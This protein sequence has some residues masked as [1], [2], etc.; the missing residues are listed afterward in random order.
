M[1]VRIA[2]SAGFCMGVRK[3]M[4]AVLEASQ[5]NLKTYTLGPLIHNPQAI[6]ML[7]SRNIY[8]ADRIDDSLAG[9]TVV[10]R[11]HG[12]TLEKRQKLS[13][14]GANIVDGTC[15][16]VLWS[17][18]IIKKYHALD[19]TIV[20][21]GDRGH[22]EIEALL[23]YAGDAGTVVETL[24]EARE[25]PGMDDVCV[26]AQTTFNNESYCTISEEICRHAVGDCH[27]AYTVCKSTERR[28]ED[29]RKLAEVTDAT[30]VVGGR[31][32]ANTR[33]LAEISRSLG[34]PTFL[35]EDSSD[36]DLKEL[37]RFSEIGVTAGASTPNWVIKQII[38]TITGYTPE[39][40]RSLQ[41]LLMTLAFFAIEGNIVLCA[42]ASALTFAL[43]SLMDLPLTWFVILMPFFYLF[44]LHAFNKYLE[45]NWKQIAGAEQ[46]QRL[47]RFW[48]IYLTTALASFIVT[49][50]IT[51]I[52]GLFTFVL[53][54][55]SYLLGFLYSIRIIPAGWNI[56][57]K[58]LR[59]I[60][61]SKDF[62][63]AAAWM[64]AVVGLPVITF[65]TVPEAT[66]IVAAAFV[67]VLV[68]TRTSL[69][70]LSGIQSD[71]LVGHETIPV[72]LGKKKTIG[73]LRTMTIL[74][75]LVIT[76][77]SI[78]GFTRRSFL[79]LVI[80]VIY[81]H[82]CIGLLGRKTRFFTL[83]H[84]MILDA[85]FF[86]TGFLALFV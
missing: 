61:G 80:P 17:E 1:K 50:V 20:I 83:Y 73:L 82:T 63:I 60:P 32:S 70:A 45:I 72:L 81:M 24:E 15:P 53:V 18:K 37:A 33:R 78:A 62:F 86:L 40:P 65:G 85:D 54:A 76:L 23:S 75:A 38:D 48:S 68:I 49:L 55:V 43:C 8:V 19:Y 22:A 35:V 84:Q 12:V 21:V 42:A 13:D 26:V 36:L 59:D 69:L 41:S 7:E 58:S 31:N 66:G 77:V 52:A 46:A 56:R 9:E 71:K 39:T 3:A 5:G 14:I 74:L 47:R 79:V 28:Q 10:I 4:D 51:W 30:V 25:L 2:E 34:Q 64:V 29:I 27:I 57:F 6:R 67:F 44:P 16:K 11:A